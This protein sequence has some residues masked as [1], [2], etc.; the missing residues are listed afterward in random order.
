LSVQAL[1]N[2]SSSS[3]SILKVSVKNGN[4]NNN[5]FSLSST[6]SNSSASAVTEN[7]FTFKNYF[8]IYP[9]PAQEVVHVNFS[10][11]KSSSYSIFLTD[12]RGKLLLRKEGFAWGL[13]NQVDLDVH[14]FAEGQYFITILNN[15][16]K[17]ATVRLVKL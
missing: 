17:L 12:L 8:S 4:G 6:L 13:Q 11:P 7:T 2:C 9:N 16:A 10:L 14:Q 5:N 15:K 3:A 1:N